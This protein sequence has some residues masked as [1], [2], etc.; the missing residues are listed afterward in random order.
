MSEDKEFLNQF[1]KDPAQ[2]VRENTKIID[3]F[4]NLDLLYYSNFRFD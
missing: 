4:L 2:I 1:L 3:F